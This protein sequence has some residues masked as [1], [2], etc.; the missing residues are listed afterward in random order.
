MRRLARGR[1]PGLR[2]TIV[3]EF[4]SR[5]VMCI[6]L[7]D[8]GVSSFCDF[9]YKSTENWPPHTSL[10]SCRPLSSC[11][12]GKQRR[13]STCPTH[14]A[15]HQNGCNCLKA[16][17]QAERTCRALADRRSHQARSQGVLLP[18]VTGVHV[19]TSTFSA[20]V[21][22]TRPFSMLS[23]RPP[24]S[25][26]IPPSK[27]LTSLFCTIF[28][29]RPAWHHREL[30]TLPLHNDIPTTTSQ[31]LQPTLLTVTTRTLAPPALSGTGSKPFPGRGEL[32]QSAWTCENGTSKESLCPWSP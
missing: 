5:V 9:L 25:Y 24:S 7:L 23:K 22:A 27:Q 13:G 2:V 18:T 26:C 1:S 10:G 16:G 28:Y 29:I 6:V 11:N 8:L 12:F 14:T 31:K 15:C 30:S 21:S 20:H 4:S 17:G 3:T 19:Y 32:L